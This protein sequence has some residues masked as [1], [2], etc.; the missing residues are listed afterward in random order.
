MLVVVS[1]AKKLDMTAVD[2]PAPSAPHFADEAAALAEVAKDLSEADLQKLMKISAPLAKLNAGRFANFGHQDTKQAAL[3]FAG[4]TYQGLEAGTLDAD[5]MAWAQEH[6]RIL[7][8]LYGL[9]RP[10]DAMEPY[11]LEMGSRL[12][13]ARGKSL[14]DWWGD[15]ISNALNAQAEAVGADTLINCASQEYFG[16]VGLKALKL[17]VIT[18]VFMEERAGTPKIISFYAKKARGAM[19]RFVI[20]NRLTTP[21]GL[22]DFDSGGYAFDAKSSEPGKLVFI[23]PEAAQKDAA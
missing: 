2:A 10:L 22:K 4:D 5:E 6:F 17:N 21:E 23:R 18:P 9:L 8:G 11:R 12:K 15:R 19:A 20:Q 7:S 13:T 3:A 14:Y 16:A 1:P